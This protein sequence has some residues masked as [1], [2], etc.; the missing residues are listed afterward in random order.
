RRPIALVS[1]DPGDGKSFLAANLGIAFAQTGLRT[2]VVDA[3]MRGP[4]L[5]ELFEL[6]SPRGL[7]GAM[8]GCAD[9]QM[10]QPVPAVPGLHLLACGAMP[11]NPLELV[12]REAFAVLMDNLPRH[13]EQ[14]L[15][16]TPAASCGADAL[17]IADRCGASLLVGR[18]HHSSM[19]DL[20]RLAAELGEGEGRLL[21]VV[22]NDF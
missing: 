12:E 15:V 2:L 4:R 21:G 7:S 9:E 22:F 6:R 14:V 19:T 5:H 8:I 16:D 1:P 3:D 11:P 20:R 13:F 10:I 18:R 17:A